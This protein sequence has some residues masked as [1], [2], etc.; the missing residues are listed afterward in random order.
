MKT[1]EPV[2]DPFLLLQQQEPL[3]NDDDITEKEPDPDEDSDGLLSSLVNLLDP[4]L[5]E[6]DRNNND[7]ILEEKNESGLVQEGEEARDESTV[8]NEATSVTSNTSWDD[9]QDFV[10]T[11]VTKR[12]RVQIWDPEIIERIHGLCREGDVEQLDAVLGAVD[13]ELKELMEIACKSGNSDV[14]RCIV[15]NSDETRELLNYALEQVMDGC[16]MVR[17]DDL[18]SDSD[19]EDDP[20]EESNEEHRAR[21]LKVVSCLIELGADVNV[22][23]VEGEYTPLDNAICS[24]RVDLARCLVQG[25]AEVNRPTKMYEPN[26]WALETAC[27]TAG[28][29]MVQFLVQECGAMVNHVADDGSTPLTYAADCSDWKM[30]DWLVETAHAD[31]NLCLEAEGHIGTI[32]IIAAARENQIKTVKLLIDLGNADV[33][34]CDGDGD[35]ALI[36]AAMPQYFDPTPEAQLETVKMLIQA[37]GNVN[38]QNKKGTTPL[39]RACETMYS[40]GPRLDLVKYLVEEAGADVS[41]KDR[42]GRTPFMVALLCFRQFEIARFLHDQKPELTRSLDMNVENGRI[43]FEAVSHRDIETVAFLLENSNADV[44]VRDEEGR[45]PIHV[46]RDVEILR[47]LLR[48]GAKVNDTDRQ[49]DK[50]GRSLLHYACSHL[51]NHYIHMIGKL[52][53][54]FGANVDLQDEKGNTPLHRAAKYGSLCA[55]RCLILGG[56]ANPTL[57]DIAGRT[58]L[59]RAAEEGN[60]NVLSYLLQ[61]NASRKYND[62]GTPIHY[63][64]DVNAQDNKGRT[65]LSRA[66]SEADQFAVHVLIRQGRASASIP[67]MKGRLPLHYASESGDMDIVKYIVKECP[68]DINAQDD[69]LET[70]VWK[71]SHAGNLDIL[72]WIVEDACGDLSL[73]D[74]HGEYPIHIA[75]RQGHYDIVDWMVDRN[76]RC[77]KLRNENGETPLHHASLLGNVDIAM[78]LLS[79]SDGALIHVTDKKGRQALHT[80][81]CG[82]ASVQFTRLLVD[83]FLADVEAVDETRNTPLHLAFLNRRGDSQEKVAVEATG[84]STSTSLYDFDEGDNGSVSEDEEEE[85]GWFQEEEE[86]E[87]DGEDLFSEIASILL[88]RFPPV[89][90]PNMQG[91]NALFLACADP[92]VDTQTLYKMVQISVAE[93]LFQASS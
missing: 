15:A 44:N 66:C 38:A 32:P 19:D 50:P 72:K 34:V 78:Q 3:M 1:V 41:I 70:A 12:K 80:M 89:T 25:G 64:V 65:A 36:T 49:E 79:A 87:S 52:V 60:V 26:C 73:C 86:T 90:S 93:G 16:T 69:N 31:P 45:L 11:T 61:Q 74:K 46:A 30:M 59:H 18:E 8:E 23:T 62:S 29:T 51:D 9:D 88:D 10:M 68:V 13:I 91:D 85:V 83:I 81:F 76:P 35:T 63:L 33:N 55:A 28:L 43:L 82:K 40:H 92:G 27:E 71:S 37:G 84:T 17:L 5:S 53:C 42:E 39:H 2:I 77:V 7:F 67:D 56:G 75:C 6:D 58:P 57:A 47:L 20:D 21:E 4:M 14:L 54:E 24:N 22:Y 48:S